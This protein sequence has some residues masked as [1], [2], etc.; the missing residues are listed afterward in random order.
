M[1]LA[2]ASQRG[3]LLLPCLALAFAFPQPVSAADSAAAPDL[4]AQLVAKSGGELG[5]FYAYGTGPL[6][7]A[8][9][10]TLDPAAVELVRLVETADEDG[11]DPAALNARQ[12]AQAVQQAEANPTPDALANAELLLSRTFATYVAALRSDSSETMTYEAA[13]LR[14]ERGGAYLTLSEAAKAP[15][16]L[17]YVRDMRWMHPLYA[18]L[19]HAVMNDPGLS[20]A[21]RQLA[22]VNLERIRQIPPQPRGRHILID[23]AN[24]TLWMYDGDRAIDSMKVVVGKPEKQ[25]PAYA[26]YIRSAFLNPYWNVPADMVRSI[27]ARNVLS[28]GMGYL[29]RQ[30]YEV[31][32][33]YSTDATVI[34]P[35]SIDWPAVRRGDL[36][37]R[38]RQR[39]GPA[40]SM[41]TVKYEFPNPYGIYLHDSPEKDVLE[42]NNR[43]QSAGCIRLEDA[44]RL[45]AWLMEGDLEAPSGAPEQRI[46]LPQP[47]PVYVTYL[48]AHVKDG[49]VALGP[50]PYARDGVTLAAR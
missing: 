43:Q 28:Q 31:V 42:G 16:L 40:N 23:S 36:Q 37:I 7:I 50:D 33:D 17:E 1:S 24:A 2:R 18:P 4:K 46:E 27:I 39:P 14:P 44:K 45:G 41:G 15:S 10:G 21:D 5:T 49:A 47:V 30:G 6:W 29:K 8:P 9:N 34:D 32:S 20:P 38:V 19:R 3:R 12:L 13:T 48:T 35:H 11:L 22:V 25:T 26:G